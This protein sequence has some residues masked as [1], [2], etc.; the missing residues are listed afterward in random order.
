MAIR[1]A[2][3]GSGVTVL[4]L[5]I[6]RGFLLVAAGVMVGVGI[7]VVAAPALSGFLGGVSP[8]DPLTYSVVVL[9]F[10]GAGLLASWLPARRAASIEP[11][12]VL[13]G[14]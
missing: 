13:K 3:G 9:T 2:L 10:C 7:A 4:G 12:E 6:R 14:R 8:T 1:V 5:V 11:G